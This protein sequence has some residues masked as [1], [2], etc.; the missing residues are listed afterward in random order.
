MGKCI[1]VIIFMNFI[2]TIMKTYKI[3]IVG[4]GHIAEKM[5]ST[6]NQM[7]NAETYAIASRQLEKAKNFALKY[8]IKKAY[9]SYK[10]LVEDNNIDL[11][12]IATPHSLHYEHAH[13]CIEYG[14]PVLC[15]KAF[16]AN[17]RQAEKLLTFA[18]EKQVF[19]TE[20]IWTRFMPFSK[21]IRQILDDGI[22]GRPM[23]LTASLS[24][25]IADKE[26]IIKPELAGGALLDIGVYPINF[27]FMC[28]GHDIKEINSTCIK[29][30]TGVDAQNSITF[31][32]NDGRMAVMQSNI[33]CAGDRQG[34][35]C[36]DKGYVVIDNINNPQKAS[37]YTEGHSLIKTLT[38]PQQISG[39]EYEVYASL[40]ALEHRTLECDDMPHN[41]TLY[42]M[43]ILDKLRHKWGVHFPIDDSL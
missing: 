40:A 43:Q 11:V 34:I 17:A 8:G 18:K 38:C 9:G 36:G 15:E 2:K 29:T 37:I 1:F 5:A 25:P 7:E 42:V 20:A 27:A 3:G 16:T 21:T 19:I 10:E 22:I 39:Y 12:Y 26:R 13:L 41:E 28:F 6:I 4:A 14:K 33:Y 30:D 24:Y 31:I 23:T 35:I 32:Y